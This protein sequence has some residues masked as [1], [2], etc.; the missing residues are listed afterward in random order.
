MRAEDEVFFLRGSHVPLVLQRNVGKSAHCL[1]GEAY[2]HG[3]MQGEMLT[4][5]FQA[6]VREITIE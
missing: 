6:S 5:E 3:F 2:L 1:V 4:P